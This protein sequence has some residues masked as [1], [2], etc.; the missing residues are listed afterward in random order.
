MCG[1]LFACKLP[2]LGI[3]LD[4]ARKLRA[5]RRSSVV[6]GRHYLTPGRPFLFADAAAV[7]AAAAACVIP[8]ELSSSGTVLSFVK[9]TI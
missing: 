3:I 4:T 5:A 6:D 1:H 2:V 7:A 8:S 9:L